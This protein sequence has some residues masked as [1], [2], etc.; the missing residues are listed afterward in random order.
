LIAGGSIGSNPVRQSAAVLLYSPESDTLIT[1]GALSVGRDGPT[2]TL[3]PE[4]IAGGYTAGFRQL[5][6]RGD[7]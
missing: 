3:L 6:R 7:Y 4:L 2:G 1:V 5:G